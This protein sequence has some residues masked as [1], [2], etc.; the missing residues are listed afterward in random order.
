MPP[1]NSFFNPLFT[2]FPLFSFVALIPLLFFATRNPRKKAAVHTFIYL[3]FMSLGQ[4]Y[5]I[6]FVTVNELWLLILLGTFLISIAVGLFYFVSAAAFRVLS[7]NL[8]RAYLFIF[9]A[10][11]VMVDYLRTLSDIS[12][13]WALIGYSSV[14]ILPLAQLSSVTGVW[15]VTYLIVLGNVLLYEYLRAVK[16][17]SSQT[18]AKG[19]NFAMWAVSV[20]LISAWGWARMGS[21]LGE[22]RAKITLLQTY[23]DQFNWTRNSIDSAFTITDSMVYVAAADEPDLI[24]L[25]ESALLCYLDR[26]VKYRDQVKSW[27]DNTTIP[28]ILGSLHWDFAPEEAW[29]DY[30]VY[31]SAFLVKPGE[32][33]EP[34]HKKKLVPFSEAMPFE[35]QIPILSRV[36]LG[37]AGFRRG[38]AEGLFSVN[39]SIKAS[40]NICY[41]IIYPSFVQKRLPQSVNLLVNITND[42]WFG[43]SSGPFQH[44]AMAQ[45]RSIENGV[46]LARSAN[47]GIS[48]SVDPLGRVINRSGL[49]E[50]VIITDEVPLIRISTFYSRFGDWFVLLSFVL[51]IFG[52]VSIGIKK[53]RFGKDR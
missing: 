28:M 42:G 40:P 39:E 19:I 9:P 20:L 24:I 21:D 11:W 4:Y 45:M 8:P 48:M 52:G 26:Q 16:N 44:A 32:S 23:M 41:E 50:R 35:A 3:F 5:W 2:P 17:G 27:V 53:S 25:P 31:N 51:T 22:E 33:L 15:G 1:F 46:S 18:K 13:P 38:T 30:Y 12:F 37:S 6:G 14:G 47:S 10:V 43:R 34:Y 36:N 7:K 29:Q 49:Y